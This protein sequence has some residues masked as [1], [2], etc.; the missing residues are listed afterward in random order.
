[1]N[2][3]DD[4]DDSD[5]YSD[6]SER[7]YAEW[8][9]YLLSY[10]DSEDDSEDDS[11]GSEAEAAA[12]HERKVETMCASLQQNDSAV[13]TLF[14]SSAYPLTNQ[15]ALVLGE[16]LQGNTHVST[17]HLAIHH[18]VEEGGDEENDSVAP[19]L[20]FMRE[21]KA[22]LKVRLN[23][24]ADDLDDALLPVSIFRR[25]FLAIAE[26]PSIDVLSLSGLTLP[27]EGFG[28]LLKTTQSLKFLE[29]FMC[30]FVSVPARDDIA[31][32]LG[33]N[34]TLERLE[35]QDDFVEPVLLHLGS[36]PRL[37]ELKLHWSE[38]ERPSH[39]D[40]LVYFLCSSTTLELL[41]LCGYQFDK[42]LFEPLLE[43]IRSSRSLTKLTLR[44]CK[45]DEES[46]LLFEQILEP[47]E[48][49]TC[50]RELSIGLNIKFHE[51]STGNMAVNILAPNQVS[52]DG[53][54]PGK[55]TSLDLLDMRG[56][57]NADLTLVCDAL[58]ANPT[59]IQ[60][61]FLRFGNINTT[62][63]DALIRSLPKLL[64]LKQLS[65]ESVVPGVSSENLLC[66]LRENGSLLGADIGP[67]QYTERP[68][69]NERESRLV[70]SYC[71]RNEV[72]PTLVAKPRLCHDGDN[73]DRTD[74][75]LFPTL[76][77]AAK[78]APRTA[79]NHVLIGLLAARD[80]IGPSGGGERF[81]PDHNM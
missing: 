44:T 76:F 36:H 13:T 62:G 38:D 32:A 11:D 22:L 17:L 8:K 54:K 2:V 58:G 52:D 41:D 56:S 33:E 24:N 49:L 57:N 3:G 12:A 29:L 4:D 27:L 39:V 14:F 30:G 81:F 69:F 51:L 9:E 43:S 60:L 1:M 78:Q 66:A 46:T 71:K 6:G 34:Q 19:L 75:G 25:F 64:Y 70:Q 63:C 59:A 80:S 72:I 47:K 15:H 61:Q 28:V 31:E 16:S 45:F 20:K 77:A 7:R 35:I 74:L 42:N 10:V 37:R 68:L 18:L 21:S 67:V 23:G 53:S 40:A 26:N 48:G 73:D 55:I 79:P 50:I 65:V 5:D